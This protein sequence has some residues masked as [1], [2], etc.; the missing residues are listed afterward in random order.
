M[1]AQRISSTMSAVAALAALALLACAVFWPDWAE[2][3]L[4][5][6]WAVALVALQ[7]EAVALVLNPEL[8]AGMA[9]GFREFMRELREL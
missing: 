2:Q 8:R 5:S 4:R 3:Q 9:R 7:C 6:R 1:R